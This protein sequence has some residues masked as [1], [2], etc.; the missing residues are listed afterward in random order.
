M[1]EL[2]RLIVKNLCRNYKN[3]ERGALSVLAF[4]YYCFLCFDLYFEYEP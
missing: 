1:Y 2:A 3:E 4:S